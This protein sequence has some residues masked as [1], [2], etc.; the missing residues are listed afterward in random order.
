MK[1]SLKKVLALLT[2]SMCV[3]AGCK[4]PPSQSS[5]DESQTS[6]VS[7][8]QESESL[9]ESES[10]SESH[11]QEFVVSFDSQGGSAVEPQTIV[12]GGKVTKPADP[13]KAAEGNT[14]Y[15]FDIWTLNDAEYDFDTE[16]HSSFTLVAR[17]I[18]TTYH[19]PVI[20]IAGEAREFDMNAGESVILP[21]VTAVDYQG[22]AL[23]VEYEDDF[24]GSRITDGVFTSKVAGRH[25]INFYAEDDKGGSSTEM[26]VINVAPAT[27]ENFA[28]SDEE[29]LPSNITTFSTYKENFAKGTNS[30]FFKSLV[31]STNAAY[32]S[33]TSEA[34][35]GNS[36]V[37][38]AKN[39]IG[40]A[41][42]ALFGKV[43]NDVVLRET[44]VTYTVSFDY[45][46]LTETGSYGGMY[47]SLSYDG[48]G[49]SMGKDTK[50]A[51]V[52][53]V[54]KHFEE[55]Y[56]RF[57]FPAAPT[58]CYLRFFN[59]NPE[60]P[61]KDSYFAV[62]N[63]VVSAKQE[64]QITYVV[65]TTEQLVADGGFTWDL[66]ASAGTFSNSTF[67]AVEEIENDAIENEI[68][69]STHF[70]GN[71]I[72]VKGAG[73]HQF[74]GLTSTNIITGKVLEVVI[75][76]YSINPVDNVIYMSVNGGNPTIAANQKEDVEVSGNIRRLTTALLINSYGGDLV[77][78]L[79]GA[80]NDE[81]YVGKII[82][83]LKDYVPETEV[84]DKPAVRTATTAEIA[85]GFTWDQNANFIDFDNS[86]Y[87]NV[88]AMSDATIKA[89]IQGAPGTFGAKVLRF[90]GGRIL[91]VGKN[92]L[93]AGHTLTIDIEYYNVS[94]NFAYLIVLGDGNN[95][96]TQP[97]SA[98]SKTV[99]EGNI[100]RLSISVVLTPE[101]LQL[102]DIVTFY[103]GE[104]MMYIGK[105][106]VKCTEPAGPVFEN[107]T[108]TAA[109]LAAGFTW[110]IGSANKHFNFDACSTVTKV[111]EIEDAT[112]KAA[113][114]TKGVTYVDH[115]DLGG[116]NAKMVGL[117]STTVPN[118]KELDIVLQYYEVT[119][120][121]HF[122]LNGS[123]VGVD[124]Q[125]DGKFVTASYNLKPTNGF[126]YFSLYNSGNVYVYSVYA[127]VA[128]YEAP[129]N[130]TPGGHEVGE[131]ITLYTSGT[132]FL[133]GNNKN[134]WVI[135]D[136]DNAIENL[137]ELEGMGT[138]PKKVSVDHPSHLI[139]INNGNQTKLENGVTY[140]LKIYVYN[141]DWQGHTF[142]SR[143]SA[144][145]YDVGGSYPAGYQVW[146]A[147]ITPTANADFLSLYSNSVDAVGS[148]YLG[149]IEVT[150]VSLAG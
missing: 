114:E 66:T 134:G 35:A 8:S 72:H 23:P 102:D 10:E 74:S 118:G 12:D 138:A 122:L 135:S 123:G 47:F 49:E 32:I 76:Y 99:I 112:I 103:G 96:Y 17:W 37:F 101:M 11:P 100:K 67:M 71:V 30:P 24:G 68:N 133:G 9:T 44:Q 63:I 54:T 90:A 110:E 60:D 82:A 92:N 61:T 97:A 131:T 26:I 40:S 86:D 46:A 129:Q 84:V 83:A 93:T 1:H 45:R 79:Y 6:E 43:I 146:E 88:E 94:D 7:E 120:V 29:N 140:T 28:V 104:V 127:K 19:E 89:A 70:T 137:A 13:T 81:I 117:N 145:F 141:I 73:S 128:D 69:N 143:D 33:G 124:V 31:D 142:I 105:V 149:N 121:Q 111:S 20:T 38:N 5:V 77:Y 115:V 119:P 22:N 108:P 125:K 85:D 48:S 51:P 52:V 87:I 80:A 55:T 53:G 139:E 14:S 15:E 75:Y 107:Y 78:N 56:S 36:L 57:V 21:E 150:V 50:L 2:F 18:A 98:Y 4:N 116:G 41:T 65:P 126:D 27:A 59:F 42:R 39:L 16:V 95:N 148:F 25:E 64:T 91:G 136:Y 3:L 106:T 113:L 62:D 132:G 130:K 109:E 144:D 34:I 58:S 147:T